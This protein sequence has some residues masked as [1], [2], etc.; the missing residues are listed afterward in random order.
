MEYAYYTLIH[1]ENSNVEL[2][3]CIDMD[4]IDDDEPTCEY[5]ITVEDQKYSYELEE[6]QELESE[7]WDWISQAL[8]E[9]VYDAT[10]DEVFIRE[11]DKGTLY[12]SWDGDFSSETAK[13]YPTG[14]IVENNYPFR[15]D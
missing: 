12:M 6:L 9:L 5:Q 13:K 4:T 7:E 3:C 15:R 10:S 8:C 11:F 2:K 1:N 14:K